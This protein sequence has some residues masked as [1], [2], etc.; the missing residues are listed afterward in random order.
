MSNAPNT[1]NFSV[2]ATKPYQELSPPL[3]RDV[4]ETFDTDS[5]QFT[6]FSEGTPATMTVASGR[7]TITNSAGTHRNDLVV[8]GPSLA[9]PQCF[10]CVDIVDQSGSP[11]GYDNIGVGLIKDANNFV[12]ASADRL[13]NEVRLQI[14]IGG[15]S[16][17]YVPVSRMIGAG[18]KLGMAL[19]G[20]FATVYV[21]DGSN[22]LYVTGRDV[23]DRIDLKTADL[24][25][26]RGGFC[27]ATPGGGAS[28]SFDNLIVGRFGGVAIRDISIVTTESGS[29]H[30]E[31]GKVYATATLVDGLGTGY[32]AV[33]RVS[34]SDYSIEQ[35]AVVFTSR[36]G[37]NHNDL[38]GHI[39][40]YAGGERKLTIG[41]W[42]NGFGSAIDTH[43]ATTTNDLLSG[44][45]LVP[46]TKLNLPVAAGKAA[47]DSFLV[48]DGALWRLAYTTCDNLSFAGSLFYSSLATSPDLS[49]WTLVRNDPTTPYEGSKIIKLSGDL[50]IVAGTKNAAR[51]YDKELNYLGPIDATFSGGTQTQP[52][53]MIFEVTPSKAVMLTFDNDVSFPGVTAG[54]TWGRM[55]VHEASMTSD[56]GIADLNQP[57]SY[58]TGY[59]TLPFGSASLSQPSSDVSALGSRNVG[60][61]TLQQPLL[62]IS[63]SGFVGGRNVGSLVAPPPIL[64]A[65]AG[66]KAQFLSPGSVMFGMGTTFGIGT[67]VFAQ[68]S[69]LLTA[70]GKTGGAGSASIQQPFSRVTG[71]AGGNAS[72]S[73][74]LAH[75]V[76]L[77]LTGAVGRAEIAQ[78]RMLVNGSGRVFAVGSADIWQ[79]RARMLS[80]ASAQLMQP[81]SLLHGFG[82]AI[83]PVTS[84]R[85][86]WC[87]TPMV[88]SS[89]NVSGALTRWPEYLGHGMARTSKATVV[90]SPQAT[91][92]MSGATDGETPVAWR[93]DTAVVDFDAPQKKTMVSAYI[94]GALPT[95][96]KYRVSASD[97]PSAEYDHYESTV[98]MRNHRQKFGRGLKAR[99]IGFGLSG[100][101]ELSIDSLELEL[102][103]HS[104]R[105]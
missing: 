22:W 84:S 5:G 64:Q 103:V 47:Y 35:T 67:A 13:N 86:A 68:P 33:V 17:F 75:I 80:A 44:T 52:H 25:G 46:T 9:I 61:A 104:R 28:W 102:A 56:N 11:S 82:S 76:A 40:Y 26:W 55:V 87:F 14:K 21:H 4:T 20:T 89:G 48:K 30:I 1:L 71:R 19:V 37:A 95:T 78:P 36:G 101:G 98:A 94:A 77:G 38:A 24:S 31:G 16:N 66:G 70:Y 79:P 99:Y 92:L 88:D 65:Q 23:G 69:P 58:I 12:I 90:T 93:F 41:T 8:T 29:P 74:P 34:L 15:T 81:R 2:V 96:T 54:F 60:A 6:K 45:W 85:V 18:Q 100:S 51:A 63:G 10:V 91:Y 39:I 42:G 97:S 57:K 3:L 59:D 32:Q 73:S 62:L 105:I 72:I 43:Y 83:A 50:Y 7:V 53:P 49:T 27:V